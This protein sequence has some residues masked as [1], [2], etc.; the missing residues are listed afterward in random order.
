MH[1]NHIEIFKSPEGRP[2]LHVRLVD[3]S[4]WLTQSQIVE[5]FDSSKANIS[6]HIKHIFQSGELDEGSTVRN[7]RTVQKEGTRQVER[8]RI[9]YNLD[10]IISVGYRVNSIRGTQ[11]RQWAT[12]RLNDFLIRGVAVNNQRLELPFKEFLLLKDRYPLIAPFTSY[13]PKL[14]RY[15]LEVEVNDLRLVEGIVG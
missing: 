1:V 15:V 2:E 11:F 12:Q 13:H 4:I 7:F 3:N 10:V 8:D 9:H 14:D 5:L 6:E